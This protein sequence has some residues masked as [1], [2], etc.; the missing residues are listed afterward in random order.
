MGADRGQHLPRRALG[1][2]AVPHAAGARVRRLPDADPRA[3]PMLE[4]HPWR[5]WR[6]RGSPRTTASGRSCK[7]RKQLA[8]ASEAAAVNGAVNDG[9]R[10]TSASWYQQVA[11]LAADRRGRLHELGSVQPHA[12][13]DPVRRRRRG[14]LAS[15]RARDALGRRRR[16]P[17]RDHRSGRRAVHAAPDGRATCRACEVG[18][19]KYVAALRPRRRDRERPDPAPAGART[20]SGSR[21]RTPTR[22]CTRSACRRSPGWMST[23]REPDVSPLQV[24][25]PESRRP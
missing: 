6:V 4:R 5:R 2:T 17:G 19:C 1:R 7:D 18:Q 14:V 15:A 8:G 20:G 21:S 23:I 16:A 24:Q 12:D 22:C 11:V 13:P 10:S 3:V 25:G 9:S